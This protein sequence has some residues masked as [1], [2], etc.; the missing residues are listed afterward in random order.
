MTKQKVLNMRKIKD[1]RTRI[2]GAAVLATSFGCASAWGAAT[3]GAGGTQ[4]TPPTESVAS[5]TAPPRQEKG[6]YALVYP[7]SASTSGS[8]SGRPGRSA[9]RP[10]AESGSE[11]DVETPL[12]QVRLIVDTLEELRDGQRETT[13]RL[14]GFTDR[15]NA[16]W[17]ERTDELAT[18][19]EAL[20]ERV[21]G[22]ERRMEELAR[23]GTR[24]ADSESSRVPSSEA[25]GSSPRVVAVERAQD[26]GSS[27]WRSIALAALAVI[28]TELIRRV[29]ASCSAARRD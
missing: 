8:S 7:A 22:M 21:S 23:L 26:R 9:T 2:F 27:V 24:R 4:A 19:I 6:E 28:V 20:G 25:S 12:G 18:S 3:D 16:G 29:A 10:V 1:L 17:R 11:Y 14:A 13:E 15:L 5:P